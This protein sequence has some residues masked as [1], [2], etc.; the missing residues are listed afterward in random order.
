MYPPK[1]VAIH[2]KI[3]VI[4]FAVRNTSIVISKPLHKIWRGTVCFCAAAY[5]LYVITTQYL[6]VSWLGWT[7]AFNPTTLCRF[8]L[9]YFL[10]L[11]LIL[12]HCSSRRAIY[13][14]NANTDVYTVDIDFICLK[15]EDSKHISGYRRY[16]NQ[17]CAQY[18]N[19]TNK[20]I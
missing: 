3:A 10:R 16:V 17:I 20:F 9:L 11:S 15:T 6:S 13:C 12:F 7:L 2:I 5:K 18:E 14:T 1:T 8:C 4:N 19:K